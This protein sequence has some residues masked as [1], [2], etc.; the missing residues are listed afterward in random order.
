ML[1]RL[2][3][4]LPRRSLALLSRCNQ[5]RRIRLDLLH[6]IMN[7]RVRICGNGAR[8]FY[9]DMFL[10]HVFIISGLANDDLFGGNDHI[11]R[12]VGFTIEAILVGHL[13]LH[14]NGF[15]RHLLVM[16]S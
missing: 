12:V 2:F 3:S 7:L 5:Q 14:V 8:F 4:A 1:R 10:G 9:G 11:V 6:D 13:N 16:T 15:L